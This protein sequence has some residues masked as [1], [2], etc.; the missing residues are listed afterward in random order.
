MNKIET[1]QEDKKL[2]R[3]I[4]WYS[5]LLESSYNYERQ[6][7][8]GFAVG[9]WPAIKRFYHTKED[10]A[11]ALVR[12]MQ[13]F[14]TT[15][16]VVSAITGVATALE[17]EA[18]QNPDFDKNTINSIKISLMGP[19]AG[20]GDSFF[21]GTIR[22]I[23]TAIALPLSQQGN[24]LGPILFLIAFNIPHM[25]VRYLGGVFGYKFG[26]NLMDSAS[27]SGI[28]A[29]ITKAATI[30]G[31]MVIGGMSAQMVKLQTV[32]SFSFNETEFLLQQ[33]IDQIFPLLLPLLY[34]L[35]MFY[36]LKNKKKSSMFLL[37]VTIAFG[38][39]GSYIGLL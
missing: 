23:A 30:V 31:L 26:T 35:F 6:Q 18:S 32:V 12:H 3:E 10:R 28:F 38:I 8:L 22:I 25:I 29:K 9:M 4:F 16:H 7:G 37:L 11:D 27:E 33:Y 1:T 20:I 36:L 39:I 14:N 21:W 13:I 15:P 5:F 24:I 17:K 2:F 19:F 34:T